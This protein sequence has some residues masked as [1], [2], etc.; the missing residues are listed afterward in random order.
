[1]HDKTIVVDGIRLE[2]EDLVVRRNVRNDEANNIE[3]NTDNDVLTILDVTSYPELVQDGIA[4]EIVNRVQQ[5]RKKAGL[6]ATD[7]VKVEYKVHSDPE[8]IGIEEVFVSRSKTLTTT[9]KSPIEKQGEKDVREKVIFEEV[10][11]VQQATFMLRLLE[12]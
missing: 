3:M 9:L 7:D 6:V 12:L 8:N 4:R 1:L 10:Q 5:L 2:E 11:E